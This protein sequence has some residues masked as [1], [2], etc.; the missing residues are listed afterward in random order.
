M[1]D[2]A[3]GPVA[4]DVDPVEPPQVADEPVPPPELEFRRRQPRYHRRQWRPPA[5]ARAGRHHHR[6]RGARRC[7]RRP[8]HRPLQSRPP[9]PPP[10]T[11]V[12]PDP[13]EPFDDLLPS[14]RGSG[15]KLLVRKAETE[16]QEGCAD[17][18]LP[19]LRM[20]EF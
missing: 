18:L 1:P 5:P 9:P 2:A 16:R 11:T 15:H 10:T 3:D 4:P 14:G 7:N 6:P 13:T 20:V 19:F 12:R 8:R 17:R